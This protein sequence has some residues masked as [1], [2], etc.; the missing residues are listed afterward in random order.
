MPMQTP[1]VI[2]NIQRISINIGLAI[3]LVTIGNKK[4]NIKIHCITNEIYTIFENRLFIPHFI[5]ILINFLI[6]AYE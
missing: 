5:I 1:L 3:V 6:T 4:I 2:D